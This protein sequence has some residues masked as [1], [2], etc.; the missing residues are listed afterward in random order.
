LATLVALLAVASVALGQAA[1]QAPPAVLETLP[2]PAPFGGVPAD[3]A[4]PPVVAGVAQPDVGPPAGWMPR[5]DADMVLW[6]NPVHRAP[7]FIDQLTLAGTAF[8]GGGDTLADENLTRHIIP[9]ARVTLGYWWMEE[10][11]WTPG[12]LLPMAG[13]ET[14]FMILGQRSFALNDAHAPALVRPFFDINDATLN[15]LIIA[16]PGIATGSLTTQAAQ[17][18]WGIEAN[19]WRNL[20]YEWPGTTCSIDGMVGFRYLNG[21]DR[22]SIG[23]DTQFVA[24]PPAAFAGLAGNRL[25]DQESF[26]A[27]NQFYGGQVGLRGNLMFDRFIVSGQFQLGVGSTNEQI[28]I[29]GSQVRTLPT[30]ATITSPGA[31][32][33]LPS[34][35]G[36]HNHNEFTLL[37][38]FGATLTVPINSNISLG[39]TFTTLYWSR[40][41]RGA[42][43]IDTA[44]NIAQLPAGALVVPPGVP[45]PTVNGNHPGV[46]FNQS[47]L[48]I[49]GAMV[50]AT[51]RW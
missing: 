1:P 49:M 4:A 45:L 12:R 37:P 21:E 17:N 36:V 51:F 3:L 6:F 26:T 9:G 41:I 28:N 23:T 18:L 2:Q 27:R 11:A 46:Q 13:F 22:V 44:I 5:I 7:T 50:T 43:Q 20:Y 34:N 42:D 29:Q 33:A 31:L 40:I 38:E 30:S 25:V 39:V 14:R 35:I 47:D 32:F 16:A 48:W 10:N 24:A 19:Y 15:A 8:I